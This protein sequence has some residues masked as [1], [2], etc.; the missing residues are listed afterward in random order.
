MTVFFQLSDLERNQAELE[1]FEIFAWAHVANTD[2]SIQKGFR[3][4]VHLF[5]G[6]CGIGKAIV[7]RPRCGNH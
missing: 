4:S 5:L 2:L 3:E 6:L 1:I 7:D